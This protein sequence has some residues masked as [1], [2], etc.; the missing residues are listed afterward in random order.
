MITFDKKTI[1]IIGIAVAVVVTSVVAYFAV[2]SNS[3]DVTAAVMR[4]VSTEGDVSLTDENDEK[5][6]IEAGMRLFDG[7]AIATRADSSAFINLDDSKAVKL[8]ELSGCILRKQDKEL[9]VVLTEGELFFNVTT[10]LADDELFDIKTSTM[11]T[12]IR[13]TSG[14]VRVDDSGDTTLALI[15][16]QVEIIANQG[17]ENEE[18]ATINAGQTVKTIADENG[19]GVR[20]EIDDIDEK[21]LPEFVID[22][23]VTDSDL[24]KE[25]FEQSGI[26]YGNDDDD[27]DDSD[28]DDDNDTDDDNDEEDEDVDTDDDNDI[29]TDDDSDDVDDDTDTE[30]DISEVDSDESDDDDDINDSQEDDSD[31]EEPDDAAD[32]VDTSDDAD[33]DTS[34]DESEDVDIEDDDSEENQ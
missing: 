20:L 16:G 13:G 26:D 27:D 29:K 33:D 24:L 19:D 22:A 25:S 8:D 32:E 2:F 14:Y 9:E 18:I 28:N 11:I 7:N 10:K 1:I 12:S 30:D 15:T 6:E 4:L 21:D 23:I 34:E 3:D 5:L 17:S 31:S